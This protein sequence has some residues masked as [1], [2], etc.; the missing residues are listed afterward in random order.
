MGI[1]P[2][3]SLILVAAMA[4]AK[5]LRDPCVP[6]GTSDAVYMVPLLEGYNQESKMAKYE[7]RVADPT[8]QTCGGLDGMMVGQKMRV[9]IFAEKVPTPVGDSGCWV[10]LGDAVAP[11]PWTRAG[12]VPI[13]DPRPTAITAVAREV[14]RGDGCNGLWYLTVEAA[15]AD[16]FAAPTPQAVPPVVVRRFFGADHAELCPTLAAPGRTGQWA[17]EDVWVSRLER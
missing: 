10:H 3:S 17:C 1:R 15:G 7:V 16:P 12:A 6:A 2:W 9:Q 5:D 8:Y 4:C 13:Q 14:A 11:T